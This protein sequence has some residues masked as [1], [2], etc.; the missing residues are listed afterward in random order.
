MLRRNLD[1]AAPGEAGRV[2]V[3]NLRVRKEHLAARQRE[4]ELRRGTSPLRRRL[5]PAARLARSLRVARDL[6]LEFSIDPDPG[7]APA[8]RL[9]PRLRLTRGAIHRD[10]VSHIRRLDRPAKH[11]LASPALGRPQPRRARRPGWRRHHHCEAPALRPVRR[12]AFDPPPLLRLPDPSPAGERM[13]V[14]LLRDQIRQRHHP[15]RG[16]IPHDPIDPFREVPTRL[17][18][19]IR[20][21]MAMAFSVPIAVCVTIWSRTRRLDVT[22]DIHGSQT[23]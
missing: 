13:S 19:V 8:R 1:V 23:R 10:I 2:H 3:L 17:L 21:P 4:I 7:D 12:L 9:D 5:C 14:K 6:A 22:I 11:S 15:K 16:D 20:S 18:R